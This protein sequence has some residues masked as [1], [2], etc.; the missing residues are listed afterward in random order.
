METGKV[1]NKISNR[2]RTVESGPGAHRDK[3]STGE[4]FKL[5]SCRSYASIIV[6][7]VFAVA[8]IVFIDPTARAR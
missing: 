2:L 8:L 4:Y 1:I 5:Y 3:R 6:G 7:L